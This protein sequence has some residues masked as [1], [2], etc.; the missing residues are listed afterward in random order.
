M[1]RFVK[2][3]RLAIW[4]LVGLLLSWLISCN[5]APPTSSSPELEFWT[6]QLQPKFTPY[7]TEVI[8]QY[9]SEN[10]GIK[11]RWVDVPWEAMESKI[12]TAVSAK[13]APDVVNLNPNFASQLASR[14]AWLDLNTQIPPEVKQQYL[15]KIWAATTL[16]DASFGIPWYLT[17][18]ITLSNQDLLSKAGIKEP[19]KTFEELADVAAKLKEKTGK[20]ALFVTFVPGDS[21]EVLESLV[22]M[23]VQLVDDQGKAAFNTPDGIAGFR[24][25]VDLYQ[26][27]LLP[28]EVLTQGHRHAIDLYQSGEIALLSSG[29]EFLTSIETNAPTIAKV[30]ATSPQITGKT[31]KKNV[32][33]MNLVIPRDTDKAEE[34]V[35]F[36]LF[37][38]NTENQLG[39][40]KAANVLPSTVEGVKR[41]IEELKQSSDSSAIAQAR[42]VS[43]MQLNDAEVLVPAMKD[44]NKLQQIIYENL[45]AAMLKEKTV[46]QAV[47]DAADAWDSI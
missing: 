36:A 38:T 6:M 30:T 35:K 1:R 13:T 44:L 32:A 4:S 43:A 2:L 8:R 41:Y 19:P 27:G 17:T 40:A 18:R 46:E 28:P 42:Q 24:Y 47:K 9:E 11:L 10:Q 14:N 37:V 7:F 22:Q 45:Q 29:A 21:G 31:G 15:P 33:V 5:A 20:Y 3:K 39:F 12:L 16:K 26:Q 23:G 25:W 34:S